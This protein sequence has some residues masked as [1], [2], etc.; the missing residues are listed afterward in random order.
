MQI[1]RPDI[2]AEIDAAFDAYEKAL[3]DNDIATLDRYF[4]DAAETVRFGVGENLYGGD[5][6]RQYRREC[7]PVHPERRILRRVT[8]SFGEAAGTV[9]I[10]FCAPD[11]PLS[12]RQMQTWVRFAE[13]WRIVAAHVS[14]CAYP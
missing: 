1:N 13:G 11:N 9:S 10:E 6:I 3:I 2:I 4:W 7:T 12:G 5:A 8:T 14:M